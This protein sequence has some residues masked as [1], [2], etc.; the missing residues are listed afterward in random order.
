MLT[1][2][3]LSAYNVLQGAVSCFGLTPG[4]PQ[5]TCSVH[6]LKI[7][8]IIFIYYTGTYDHMYIS[9]T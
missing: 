1:S 5:S 2:Y 6:S 9:A 4:A 8:D 3:Q 7:F